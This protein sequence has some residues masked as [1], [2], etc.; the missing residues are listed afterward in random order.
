MRRTQL[1]DIHIMLSSLREVLLRICMIK[2]DNT[3]DEDD[4]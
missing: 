4:S 3:Y 2:Y 1:A